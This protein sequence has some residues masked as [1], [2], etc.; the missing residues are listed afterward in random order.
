MKFLTFFFHKN[1]GAYILGGQKGNIIIIEGI[2]CDYE[3]LV[4]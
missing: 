2:V 4:Y 1:S 3:Q